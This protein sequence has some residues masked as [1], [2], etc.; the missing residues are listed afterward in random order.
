MGK[1]E[2]SR[3]STAGSGRRGSVT[4]RARGEARASCPPSPGVYLMKDRAGRGH[5]RRQGGEPAQP[6][7]LVLQPRTRRTPAPSSPLLESLLGD[8][9][10]V[11][12]TNEKEA[13]L[14]ENE[15]IKKHQPRFNVQ[16]R[17][18]KNFICLR[19]D[20]AHPTTRGSR[21]CAAFKRR[22][23]R[24]T[25]ARTP[26]ASSI[27]E[28]LRIVNRYFQLRTC[29]DHVL[30]NRKRPCLLLPDRPLPGA[31]RAPDRPPRTTA[32]ASTR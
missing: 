25:S 23:A 21:W 7:A 19:L 5:L 6:G 17:D 18:D 14:L 32:R 24:A 15:L 4:P 26:R 9:E 8:L 27:R 1:R 31:V 12:V 13:L 20:T 30:E 11:V 29:T 16:L 22:T 10:T 2:P 3:A 28:T